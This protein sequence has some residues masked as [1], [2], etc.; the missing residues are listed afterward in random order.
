MCGLLPCIPIFECFFIEKIKKVCV[1]V[2]EAK[3]ALLPHLNL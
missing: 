1:C 2:V 3:I